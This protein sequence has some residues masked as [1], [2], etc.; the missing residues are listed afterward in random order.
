MMQQAKEQEFALAKQFRSSQLFVDWFLRQ[1]KFTGIVDAKPVLI[2]DV[3]P[4]Y[5]AADR[6]QSETAVLVVFR[7]TLAGTCFALHIEN[8]TAKDRFRPQ[9]PES[10]RKRAKDWLG[11]H[12]WGNYEDFECLLLAPQA[13]A[14]KHSEDVKK[15]DRF[16]SHES[17]AEVI[18]KFASNRKA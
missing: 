5:Q 8:K 16:I 12:K 6:G 2:R 11:K 17:L 1:T 14:D 7:S 10:C 13:F 9:Q 3:Y 18:P 15:F 4:W